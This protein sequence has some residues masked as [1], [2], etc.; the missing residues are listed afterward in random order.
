V[1]PDR[2]QAIRYVLQQAKVGDV[3]LIAGKGH[4]NYQQIGDQRFPFSDR[5][6]VATLLT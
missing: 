6:L 5:T 3:V 2:Q 1:I 4:E